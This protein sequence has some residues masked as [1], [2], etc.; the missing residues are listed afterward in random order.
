[1]A[2][3]ISLI[4]KFFDE[5]SLGNFLALFENLA[6]HELAKRFV[7]T[8]LAEGIGEKIRCALRTEHFTVE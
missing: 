4:P 2:R 6:V 7:M 1:M 5:A 3:S 8:V